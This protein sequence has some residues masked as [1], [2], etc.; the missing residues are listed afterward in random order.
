[1]LPYGF[2]RW[3]IKQ[4][5]SENHAAIFYF[6]PWEVD[7]DQPRVANAPLRS[8]LRHYTNLRTMAGK[9]DR[10]AREFSWGRVDA[11]AAEERRKLA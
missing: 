6:H 9:L 11:V 7:P 4:V 5:N 1:L 10:L 3:A 2:S 8:K